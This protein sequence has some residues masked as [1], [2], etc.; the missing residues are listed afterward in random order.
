MSKARRVAFIG[1]PMD[2]G[3]GRRGVDMGP[4]AVRIAGVKHAV[5]SLG[6]EFVDHGNVE[7]VAPES[8]IPE[9]PNARFLEEIADACTRLAADVEQRMGEGDFPLVVGGDHSIAIGTVSGIASH[10]H[11]QNE[12]VGLIWFDA[13]GDMNT[14]E[15][16]DSGNIHGMPLA[17]LLG[18]GP[19]SLTKISKRFPAVDV[20]NAVLVGIRSL[21]PREREMVRKSG[22]RCITMKEVDQF[23]IHQ[24]MKEAIEIA[25][26]GTAGF[27][28][29]FDLDGTDP[30]VAPGVG[31]PVPGGISYREAHTVLEL[32]AESQKLVGLEMTEI[33]PILDDR[34]RTAQ[35][36]V[37]FIESALGR[38]T[39]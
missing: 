33:N 32:C 7:V 15:T 10:Y 9:D 35:V 27:H 26:R 22:V 3:G 39:L 14:P 13:H 18:Y 25:T 34:N 21:D 24:V 36:T 31:T 4:S 12:K 23:G 19:D 17:A 16:S 5:E 6:L 37:Q 1:V 28:L 2:L 38:R 8:R 11:K 29:S 20:Q 30:S